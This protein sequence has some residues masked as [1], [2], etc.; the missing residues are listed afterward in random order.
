VL[1]PL[2]QEVIPVLVEAI[3]RLDYP[4]DRH[5]IL[6]IT[7]A[8]DHLTRRGRRLWAMRIVTVPE[9]SR[10]PGRGAELRLAGC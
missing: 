2:Y 10:K 4:F 7:E 3:G 5:E 8:D 9:D 6:F 1:V